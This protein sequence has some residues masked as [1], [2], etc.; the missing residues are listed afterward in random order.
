[1]RM[2]IE[3]SPGAPVRQLMAGARADLARTDGNQAVGGGRMNEKCLCSM[4]H[5]AASR[6]GRTRRFLAERTMGVLWHHS[7][8]NLVEPRSI[9]LAAALIPRRLPE[10]K[11]RLALRSPRRNHRSKK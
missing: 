6:G 4:G 11:F 8:V 2:D 5:P 3:N 1:M 9:A 10:I 7:S